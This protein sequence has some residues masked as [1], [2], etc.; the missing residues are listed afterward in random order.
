MVINQVIECVRE[1]SRV[2]EKRGNA[3]WKSIGLYVSEPKENVTMISAIG[4][5]RT[6]TDTDNDCNCM[7]S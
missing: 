4:D 7:N 5:V 2:D 3:S 1:I 6:A